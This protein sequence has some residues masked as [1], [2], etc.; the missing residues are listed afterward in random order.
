MT[1]VYIIREDRVVRESDGQST[2]LDWLEDE[3]R[4]LQ[5]RAA[6]VL[7]D[8]AELATYALAKDVIATCKRIAT[9]RFVPNKSPKPSEEPTNGVPHQK[10]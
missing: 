1:G 5:D 4:G 6:S 2:G 9:A 8:D 10:T 3:I 7:S